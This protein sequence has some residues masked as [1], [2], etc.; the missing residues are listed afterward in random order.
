[1]SSPGIGSERKTQDA[2]IS[3]S[4]LLADLRAEIAAL[5]DALS[6]KDNRK[7]IFTDGLPEL[8]PLSES[9]KFTSNPSIPTEEQHASARLKV[10]SFSSLLDLEELP[11]PKTSI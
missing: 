9:T 7:S 3:Q 6:A 4:V 8:G 11:Y 2:S 1:M 5:R 10:S